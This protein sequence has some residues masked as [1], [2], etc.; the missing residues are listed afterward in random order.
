MKPK[1]TS[2]KEVKPARTISRATEVE[3]WA[4]AA[5]RCEFDGCNE[6]LYK[7]P[8]TQERVNIAQKA[9]IYSFSPAG[10]RGRGV[11][12][13]DTTGLNE[14]GNLALVCYGCHKKIDSDK[15][16]ER[17]S[18]KLI[19]FWK[20]EHEKRVQIVTEIKATKQSEV[21][22]YHA[23]IGDERSPMSFPD[24]VEA[25][26]PERYPKDER[27]T[28]LSMVS[29]DDDSTV[30]YWETESRNLKKAFERQ[31]RER[32]GKGDVEHCSVFAFAPQPLLIQL[33]TLLT[34]KV[35][36]AVYQLHREPRN[37][38]WQPHEEGFAFNLKVPADTSGAPV[39]A[40]SLSAKIASERISAAVEGNISVWEMSVTG[41]NNDILKSNLQLSMFR[42]AARKALVAIR[43][44]HPQA[45][46]LKIFPA[47]P[48]ACAVEL[49][50]IRSP[51]A[52]LPWSIFDQNNKHRRFIPAL[53]IK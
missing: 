43:A 28:N 30:E 15:K 45:E 49:G 3:L 41:P 36:A 13:K 52:D 16:G 19:K 23:K 26:F 20:E 1:I 12:I 4:R 35:D 9:H 44:V 18:A 37:W 6:L 39:L 7:S 22:F 8:V 11:F 33:G 50:R 47:M 2:Q 29:E 10:P 38:K 14:V 21:I 24:A 40:F 53:A 31:L 42:E 27:P 25:M 51:K 17:Y 34:D 46:E 5:G 48:I 32:I